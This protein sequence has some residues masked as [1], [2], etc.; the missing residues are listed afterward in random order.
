LTHPCHYTPTK[1]WFCPASLKP[2][3]KFS[4]GDA[5]FDAEGISAVQKEREIVTESKLKRDFWRL[6]QLPGAAGLIPLRRGWFGKNF[7][8]AP[9]Y[10]RLN[11]GMTFTV[12]I[13]FVSGWQ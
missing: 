12:M 3:S 13:F 10:W 2:V 5:T 8:N 9:G 11:E 4:A 7:G 1:Y 6:A